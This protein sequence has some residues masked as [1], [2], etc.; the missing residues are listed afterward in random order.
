MPKKEKY[1]Y[2]VFCNPEEKKLLYAVYDHKQSA[3][4]YACDLIRYRKNRAK[5]FGYDFGYYH[6]NP[7]LSRSMLINS[8]N[9][10]SFDHREFTVFSAC[11]KTDDPSPYG[12]NKCMVQVVRYNLNEK[13]KSKRKSKAV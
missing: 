13:A 12:D 10:D 5:Q 3:V 7:L 1:V 9:K 4:K 2:G 6:F 8:K 11:I